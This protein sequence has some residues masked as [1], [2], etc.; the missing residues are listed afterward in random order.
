MFL[1]VFSAGRRLQQKAFASSKVGERH[2]KKNQTQK[3]RSKNCS[4]TP[5]SYLRFEAWNTRIRKRRRKK[6]REKR[7]FQ[8]EEQGKSSAREK[9]HN[10]GEKRPGASHCSLVRFLKILTTTTDTSDSCGLVASTSL[11]KS[12]T[13][14]WII[15]W[16]FKVSFYSTSISFTSSQIAQ[17]LIKVRV[18]WGS[19]HSYL[20][21]F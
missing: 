18:R 1:V 21:F 11:I 8:G 16:R 17:D 12:Q 4:P 10:S 15:L 7:T 20:L 19:G 9:L 5:P 3:K 13:Q 14:I 6:A 2:K